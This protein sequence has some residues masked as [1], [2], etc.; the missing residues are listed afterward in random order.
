MTLL[1]NG[2][3]SEG[4]KNPG[5]ALFLMLNHYFCVQVE[6]NQ[7]EGEKWGWIYLENY[8][9]QGNTVNKKLQTNLPSNFGNQSRVRKYN[10]IENLKQI[11]ENVS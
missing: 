9:N 4:E 2:W 10:Y 7:R 8:D 5:E 6:N 1:V 11:K 3:L